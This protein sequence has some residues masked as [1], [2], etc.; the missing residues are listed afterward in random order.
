M[1]LRFNDQTG[2]IVGQAALELEPQN[3][4]STVWFEVEVAARSPFA[5]DSGGGTVAVFPLA[6]PA[7]FPAADSLW[8]RYSRLP[9]AK[10]RRACG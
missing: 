6:T 10:V 2:R 3:H 7:A 9:T 1:G 5:A 4:D 8:V